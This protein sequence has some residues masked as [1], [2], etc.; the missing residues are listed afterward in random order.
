MNFKTNPRKL[1][2]KIQHCGH[3]TDAQLLKPQR[4][5]I[6]FEGAFLY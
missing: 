4:F 3:N 1:G 6:I 2:Q 5:E